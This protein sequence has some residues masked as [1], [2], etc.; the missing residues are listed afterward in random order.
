M[1]DNK[2][3]R[4]RILYYGDKQIKSRIGN[5]AS[6]G[7]N[8]YGIAPPNLEGGVSEPNGFE[9][10]KKPVTKDF[11]W[12]KLDKEDTYLRIR[13]ARVVDFKDMKNTKSGMPV[14]IQFLDKLLGTM[15]RSLKLCEFGRNRAYIDMDTKSKLQCGVSVFSGYYASFNLFADGLFLKI[16]TCSK[17][18]RND[19]VLET[20]NKIYQI[21]SNSTKEEKRSIIKQ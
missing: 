5:Y 6:S 19:N 11:V 13:L 1:A 10:T 2:K 9:K 14:Y 3:E 17:M 12:L 8:L 21:S 20:I 18:I 7:Q 4:L 15:M 16:D